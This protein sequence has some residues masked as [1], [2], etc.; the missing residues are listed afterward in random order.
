MRFV[1][2]H[3]PL[4]RMDDYLQLTDWSL[5]EEVRHWPRSANRVKKRLGEEWR[6]ILHRDVMWK[7]AYDATLSIR[8]PG[9]GRTLISQ[10]ALEA[11]IKAGLPPK[12][13]DLP[14]RVDL[15]YQD[16]RPVNPLM[17]GGKQIYVYNPSSRTV[18]KEPLQEFL[19]YIPARLVQCR[20]FAQSHDHDL[21]LAAIAEKV[22]GS[23]GAHIKTNV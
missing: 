21:E 4:D 8:E 11:G 6:K 15:A 5:I 22:L 3:N 19:D 17:M 9:R 12:L 7:M 13:K 18:S 20:I 10:E 1:F 23:E 14:F 2:P 16:P